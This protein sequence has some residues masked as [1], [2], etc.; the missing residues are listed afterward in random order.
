MTTVD[1][2]YLDGEFTVSE[3]E[4]NTI[5]EVAELIGEDGVV[6]EATNNLRY[7]N[8]YPRV[9]TKVSA[10]I[11]P[12]FPRAVKEEKT[13]KDGTVKQIKDSVNNHLRDYL[14]TGDEAR[15]KLQELFTSVAQE[16]PL[17]AKGERSGGGGKLSQGALDASNGFFAAGDDKVESIIGHIESA[18]AGYKVARD[19]DG[20]AT[21]E[22]LARAIQTF[23]KHAQ[24]QAEKAAVAALAA[25]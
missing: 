20:M 14:K 23:G 11:E 13:N 3:E 16:E 9:Y 5:A 18:M 22:S 2:D 25:A 19:A 8:K 15:V 6:N 12:L 1:I 10:A 7:R 21:P 24:K 4:P 17:Y